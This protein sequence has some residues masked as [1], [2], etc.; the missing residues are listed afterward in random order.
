MKRTLSLVLALVM[1]LG[2]FT[3]AFAATA[4]PEMEAGA[5]LN[6]LGVL[7]GDAKGDLMLGA[8][9]KRQ[10]AVIMLSRLMGEEDVA[11]NFPVDDKDNYPDVTDSF[12]NGYLAWA[13]ANGTFIGNAEG[14]FRF[15]ESITTQEYAKVLLT[16]LG[17]KQDVD[18][19]WEETIAKAKELGLVADDA[20]GIVVRGA[21]AVMTINSLSVKMKDGTMTLAEKLELTLPGPVVPAEM[22]VESV[23][24]NNY[25]QVM[26]EFNTEVDEKSATN[27]DNYTI[28]SMTFE[29]AAVLE[30]G[31]TVV[32]TLKDD[33]MTT[34]FDAQKEYELTIN[35]VEDLGM[36]IKLA[37]VAKKFTPVDTTIPTVKEV[38]GLGTKAIKVVFSEPVQKS[39]ANSTVS[40]KVDGKAISGS[41]KY[42]F[43]NEAIITTNV[44]VGEHKLA[45]T[46]V[47]DFAGYAVQETGFDFT[48]VEDN[49]AP[50]IVSAKSVDLKEV[51]LE[52][53]EPIKSITKG[54]HTS[55]SNLAIAPI[56][57]AGN[58]VTLKFTSAMSLAN[59]TIYVNG[60][61]DYSGN[62]ADRNIVIVP[63]LDQTRPEVANVKVT[64]EKKFEV[65]FNKDLLKTS[66]EKSAN[67]VIKKANGDVPSG[68]GLNTKGEVVV[69]VSYDTTTKKATFN[70]VKPLPKGN[71][72]LVISGIQDASYIANSMLPYTHTFEIGDTGKPSISKSW[73]EVSN[74]SGGKGDSYIYVQFSEDMITSGSG[75]VLDIVKYNHTNVTPDAYSTWSPMPEDTTIDLVSSDT[76]RINLPRDT[77]TKYFNTATPASS[78]VKGI[79]VTLVA[80]LEDNYL[81]GLVDYEAIEVQGSIGIKE[82]KATAT[83]TIEVEFN[84][85]L[86]NVDASDFKIGT[87]TLSLDSFT[88]NDDGNTV[89]ILKLAEADKVA[90]AVYTNAGYAYTLTT[91]SNIGSQDSFGTK[92]AASLSKNVVDKINPT[93]N[94]IKIV[95]N[96]IEVAFNEDVTVADIKSVVSVKVNNSTARDI[97][98][99]TQ[100]GGKNLLITLTDLD[101]TENDIVEVNLLSANDTVKAVKD[102]AGNAAESFQKYIVHKDALNKWFEIK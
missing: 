22:K 64:D 12:Y 37:K 101:A 10:D 45:V 7:K 92:V 84:G 78:N 26:V 87:R 3:M 59:T 31:K 46:G 65:T 32:L 73:F 57:V 18:F 99:I 89:A 90:E 91:G 96:T 70:L 98:S 68:Y 11:I 82:V 60:V 77:E 42:V 83:D 53:N 20:S 33:D 74:V 28:T 2:T 85:K 4:T 72:T 9:L 29:E 102:V 95:G 67:Y 17:Y 80:D 66:A 88:T 71:Y 1:V 61:E 6:D 23:K 44:V 27:L 58:K 100:A 25:K 69:G 35:N 76:V 15:N 14:N 43:P 55:T 94:E 63:E 52:F 93:I 49:D 16:A 86:S 19:T 24:A 56:K 34:K 38:V 47:K 40:Y 54:Y 21:I 41:V 13:K 81:A 51:V 8:A 48:V 39:P 30:D 5:V 36:N 79:R 62:K 97:V 50:E 75:N